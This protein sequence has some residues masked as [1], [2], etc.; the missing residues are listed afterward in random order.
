MFGYHLFGWWYSQCKVGASVPWD[1]LSPPP[2]SQIPFSD[3]FPANLYKR[4]MFHIVKHG[5]GR[6]VAASVL[7]LLAHLAYFDS[8][9]DTRNIVDRLHRGYMFFKLWCLANS[10]TPSLKNFTK[11]N[12]HMTGSPFPYLG[13]KGSD[14]TLVLMFLQFFIPMCQREM[15]H[16]DHRDILSA[17]MQL[18]ES[19]LNFISLQY[20]HDL[21]LPTTCAEFMYLEGLVA[22][23]A[24]NY[25]AQHGMD[26]GKPLFGLRPK[27]HSLAETVFETKMCVANGHPYILTPLVFSCEGNE[28]FIGRVARISRRVSSRTCTLRTLQR[29]GVAFQSKLRR[30]KKVK[31]LNLYTKWKDCTRICGIT[32]VPFC[33]DYFGLEH[34]EGAL[35]LFLGYVPKIRL[36]SPFS[37]EKTF[38]TKISQRCGSR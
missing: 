23:R 7:I 30:L 12:L 17:V 15:K 16:P 11:A 37:P 28:D 31:K 25:A 32:C 33:W 6:E 26:I 22:L 3:S 20:S 4:D 27:F 5:V 29:Y 8:E 13:G 38:V 19:L 21:W 10:K 2:L 34:V 36:L 1:P 24:Y 18:T 35:L 14:T 9:D